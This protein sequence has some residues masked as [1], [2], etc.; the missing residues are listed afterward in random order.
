MLFG[1]IGGEFFSGGNVLDFSYFEDIKFW[2][3]WVFLDRRINYNFCIGCD[4]G[5]SIIIDFIYSVFDVLI[6][7]FEDESINNRGV[8]C[9][10]EE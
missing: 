7:L 8:L 2:R 10:H 1:G 9:Y 6:P 4:R 5:S 3:L